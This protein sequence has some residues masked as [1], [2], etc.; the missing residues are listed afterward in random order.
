MQLFRHPETVEVIESGRNLSL[1]KSFNGVACK[2]ITLNFSQILHRIATF[3]VESCRRGDLKVVNQFA[4][5][6][7]LENRESYD[8]GSCIRRRLVSA[9]A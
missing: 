2:Q 7:F 1:F 6:D 4:W 8:L 3:V 9:F 5:S